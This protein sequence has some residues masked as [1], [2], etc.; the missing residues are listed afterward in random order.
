V[1]R[2]A[3][4]TRFAEAGC[5][6]VGDAVHRLSIVSVVERDEVLQ[7]R[8]P[9]KNRAREVVLGVLRRRVDRTS[10]QLTISRSCLTCSSRHAG[11]AAR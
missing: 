9:V 5:D 6:G 11:S 1:Q 8:E 7:K 2:A 3:A 10:Q 4:K